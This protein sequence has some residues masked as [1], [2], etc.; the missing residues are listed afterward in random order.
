M[1]TIVNYKGST[2]ATLDNETKTLTT[3]G[4][5][6]EDDIEIVAQTPEVTITTDGA[7]T[8]ALQPN[9]IYHFTS[10]ELTSLTITFAGSD[11]TRDQYHFDFISPATAVTLTLPSTVVMES[12]FNVEVNTK[13]EID[14]VNNEG[15]Y[16]EW[17]VSSS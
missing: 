1:S 10:T 5:W 15:V 12:S 4:T 16:A 3:K 14:I 6:L 9:T 11:I 13:Y 8:Q 2:I 7:V 17:V